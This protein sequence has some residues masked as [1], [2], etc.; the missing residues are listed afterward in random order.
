M[1]NS[2]KSALLTVLL[3]IFAIITTYLVQTKGENTIPKCSYLDPITV[4][5]VAFSVAIFLI[6]EGVYK[7][8]TNK[9]KPFSQQFF[10]SVRVAIGFAILTIHIMQFLHK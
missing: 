4:D 3:S 10:R 5:L 1:K 6:I 2:K 9:N 8:G 7:L